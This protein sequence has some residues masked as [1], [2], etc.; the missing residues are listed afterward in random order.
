[1]AVNGSLESISLQAEKVTK[2]YSTFG[3]GSVSVLR[4]LD[5]SVDTGEVVAITGASGS[6]KSTLLH[7]LAGLD[8][9]DEGRISVLGQCMAD[10][11]PRALAEFRNQKLGFVYQFHHLIEELTALEN[12]A[13]PCMIKG[14]K[15]GEADERARQLLADAGLSHRL[16]HFPRQMS[17]GE[18]Q[19]CAISRALINEPALLFA[20]EPTGNLDQ[21][22]AAEAAERLVAMSRERGATVLLVTHNENL[23]DR[24]DRVLRLHDGILL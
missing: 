22:A 4:A 14:M 2:T 3:Q 17:G 8:E 13:L 21:I 10:M 23:A 16:G 11:K 24:A 5:L 7:V 6:G 9:A 15:R 18:R 12:V 20:D 19:R 1:M